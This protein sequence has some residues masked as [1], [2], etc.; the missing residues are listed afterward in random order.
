M[1]EPTQTASRR[2]ELRFANVADVIA[3]VQQLRRGYGQTGNWSLPQICWHLETATRLRMTPGPFPANTPEQD[4]RRERLREILATGRL[5]SGIDAP[6]PAIPPSNVDESAID[7]LI[8]TLTRW[9]E[10]TGPIAPHRLFGNMPEA[11]LR[12]LNLIHCAHHLSYLVPT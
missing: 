8:A 3:D 1:N 10:Y 9:D 7:S 5:P 12:K 6:A 11:D 2:E 4:A